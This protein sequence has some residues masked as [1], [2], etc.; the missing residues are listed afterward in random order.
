MSN[1]F[2]RDGFNV[3]LT[4]SQRDS[5]R[6]LAGMTKKIR[7]KYRY[8]NLKNGTLRN[9]NEENLLLFD[10]FSENSRYDKK[11]SLREVFC[12]MLIC[13]R[14]LSA[15]MAWGITGKYP[16]PRCLKTAYENCDNE[17]EKE[18]LVAGIP[19]DNGTKKIPLTVSKT[20][21]Y[22]FNDVELH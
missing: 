19:Y 21:C 8:K 14:G 15:G 9:A 4:K 11:L 3:K 7:K 10:E 6:F 18:K 12:N 16:T 22:L 1:T 13:Q 5:M 17:S 2:V 20:L